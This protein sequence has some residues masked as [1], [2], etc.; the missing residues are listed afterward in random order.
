MY[1]VTHNTHTH[2][3]MHRQIETHYTTYNAQ[4]D[5]ILHMHTHAHTHM[6]NA[7]TDTICNCLCENQPC[8]HLVVIRETLVKKFELKLTAFAHARPLLFSRTGLSNLLNY[9]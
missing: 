6:H 2:T 9:L 8:S 4:T 3:C 1:T 5:T 7:Q